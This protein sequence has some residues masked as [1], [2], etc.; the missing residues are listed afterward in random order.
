[1]AITKKYLD[2]QGLIYL[3]SK[4]QGYP[5]NEV[6]SAVINAID[7]AKADKTETISNIAYDSS[8]N[9]LTKT[10]N[11]TTSDV[12]T[13]QTLLETFVHQ[14][15]TANWNANNTLVG[16]KDH[17]YIYTDYDSINNEALAG[18]KIGDGNAYLIDLPFINGNNTKL[19]THIADSVS[20]ITSNERT[21]WNDKVT[22]Y[23]DSV[24]SEMIV[25]SKN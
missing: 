8:N 16:Q 9:K 19:N 12:V 6:L 20:H 22:C 1:M 21:A 13:I 25:F 5:T 18:V 2:Q 24:D 4:M 11:G 17:I 10:I 15:T 14:D 7:A 3:L 23:M